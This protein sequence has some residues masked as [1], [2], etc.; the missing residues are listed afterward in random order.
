MPHTMLFT[1]RGT[2]LLRVAAALLLPVALHAQDTGTITGRVSD[3][4]G[5]P[6][7]GASISLAGT[8][9]GAIARSDGSY[10]FLAPAGRYLVRARLLGYA[11]ATDSVSITAGATVQQNFTLAKAATSLEAVTVLGTRG[12]ARSV[13]DAP[14]PIDVLPSIEMRSTGRTETSQMIQAVAPSFNFPRTTLGDATDNVRPATLRGLSPDQALVLVNGKRRHLSSVVNINGFVGRG[15]EAV[16]LNAIPASMIDHIEILRDGAAAQYGSDAIAGVINIVLKSTAPGDVTAQVGEYS[17]QEPAVGNYT[18]PTYKHDGKLFYTDLN[19]GFR[20]GQNG[21]LF[22][23]GEIR[24]RGWTNR[25]APD[26]RQQY[27]TN[28][29]RNTDPNLPTPGRITFRIGDSYNHDTMG[30]LNTGTTLSNG[31]Q[32]YAFGGLSRRF[33]DAFAFWRRPQDNN[34]VRQIYP[35]GFLP[36]EQPVILDGSG[37]AGVKGT[38]AGWEYDLSSGYGRN[39]FDMNVVHSVNVSMG[40]QSP[41]DFH[42]GTLA[43]GQWTTTLD[44]FRN[45][46]VGMSAPL[47][48]AWGL[49]F[50][51]DQYRITP[52]DT[53]SYANGGQPVYDP[54]G[55]PTTT[56]GPVGSQ[57][58]PGFAPQDAGNHA[59]SNI[60][61]Y[62]D[63]SNDITTQLFVDVAGRYE[64]YSDFG[65]TTTGKIAAR[66][67]PVKG[68]A[69][70][71]AI[72][73]GFRAPSLGQEYFANTAI[74]FVGTPAVPLE[75]RTFPVTS[76]VAQVLHA[77]PLKPEKSMNYSAGIAMEPWRAL[78]LTIDYYRIDLDDRI[79]LSNNFTG[80]AVSDTLAAHGITNVQGARYF[81][82]AVDT[83]TNGLDVIANYGWPFARDGL[84]RVTAAYNGN[85]TKVTRVDSSSVIPGQ[86][87][88][89]FSRVDRTRLEKGNP[90]NNLLFSANLGAGRFGIDARTH[91]FGEVTSFGTNPNGS[92][93]QTWGAKWVTDLSLSFGPVARGT[94][95]LGAD[96]IGNAYPDP[97]IANNTNTGILPYSG[98]APFGIN[99][100]F[101]YAKVSFGL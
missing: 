57:A 25:A 8:Q 95:T 32:L 55:N 96:N 56:P 19:H 94:V 76:E 79:V 33:G 98:I 39:S 72:S 87:V 35:N 17:T 52:G 34:N 7:E 13:I 20:F 49:E 61:G 86:G 46:G 54:S 65:S 16:D 3:P 81:T 43:F 91:R 10:R 75:I 70:R 67:E 31:M 11:V 64:H 15:S 92:G 21:F 24:D 93:D 23:G 58:Y 37:F 77:T 5:T 4:A 42:A 80:K 45:I 78:G 51:R 18:S 60:A 68:Y 27:F 62:L 100:R 82:N 63:L 40:T 28:D 73:S 59:R 88:A 97:N 84:L 30:W 71:G 6:L 9:R 12:E 2:T 74:N 99:G 89:L 36:E 41:T 48:A 83:R 69:L 90:R 14:V 85:W 1:R 22:M 29:P 53:A 26:L 47:H 50:R 66:Y 38:A 101:L 44:A